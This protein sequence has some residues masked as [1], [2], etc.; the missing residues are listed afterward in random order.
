MPEHNTHSVAHIYAKL[1]RGRGEG[2]LVWS[3]YRSERVV[4]QTT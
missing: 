4:E 1:T 2:K 3:K